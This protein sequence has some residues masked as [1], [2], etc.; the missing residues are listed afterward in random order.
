MK[1]IVAIIS[2]P[3]LCSFLLVLVE[4]WWPPLMPWIIH[5]NPN[6]YC[7]IDS[8][9]LC[10]YSIENEHIYY[11]SMQGRR[12]NL[13][14]QEA[15]FIYG[16]VKFRNGAYFCAVS[17]LWWK[18]ILTYISHWNFT[19]QRFYGYQ[20]SSLVIEYIWDEVM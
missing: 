19:F 20:I 3:L 18:V 15:S 8:M 7:L 13:V 4:G 6:Q 12:Y 10:V 16:T 9:L 17:M 5:I 11:Y 2:T 1:I 14:F